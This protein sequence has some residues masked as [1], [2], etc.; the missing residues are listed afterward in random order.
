MK[1]IWSKVSLSVLLAGFEEIM[2]HSNMTAFC[3]A[4]EY[5]MYTVVV[6]SNCVAVDVTV[7]A[8]HCSADKVRC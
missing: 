2:N 3:V 7:M 1:T 6:K 8:F 4:V 5:R